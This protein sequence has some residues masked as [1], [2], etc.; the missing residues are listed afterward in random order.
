MSNLAMGGNVTVPAGGLTVI[1]EWTRS[2]ALDEIDAAAFLLGADGR[3]SGDADMVFYGQRAAEAVR[4]ERAPALVP[5]R[6]ATVFH[7]D[8]AALAEGVRRIAF[9]GTLHGARETGMHFGK[10]D[11]LRISVRSAQGEVAAFVPPPATNGETALVLGE[12]YRRDAAWKFR[13]VGQGFAGGLAPLARTY[14]VDVDEAAPPPVAPTPQPTPAAPPPPAPPPPKPISL[15]KVSLTKE[16]PSV[17]LEK[18]SDYGDVTVNLNWSRGKPGGLSGMFQRGG[19]ID[20]DLGCLYELA[21]GSKGC[22]QALGNGFGRLDREP[23]VA[24][25]ADDRSG[26]SADGEWMR[27]NGRYFSNIRRVLVF[28]FIYDGVPNWSRTDGIVTVG[29]PGEGPIEVRMDEGSD[30]KRMCAVALIENDTG[31]MRISREVAYFRGH[32]D[33][34]KAYRWG[35]RW[36][37]GSKD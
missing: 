12:L 3:V 34:D 6:D 25:D 23:F 16:R 9:S 8:T 30:A 27:V 32:D 7:I 29:V 5:G 10:V 26:A 1:V 21:D 13:A 36:R 28:A 18:R 20:L 17:S 19:G 37:A 31:R 11:G 15:S 14:G 24:L 33:M 4:F 22:V 35:L 2:P